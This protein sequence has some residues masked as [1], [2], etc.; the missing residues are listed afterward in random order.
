MSGL[1][2]LLVGLM[3]MMVLIALFGRGRFSLQG[4]LMFPSSAVSFFARY[5]DSA[6]VWVLALGIQATLAVVGFQFL[7]E[8]LQQRRPQ[9]KPGRP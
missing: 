3:A 4:L 7:R 2:I 6:P 9:N 5:F 8:D 1:S